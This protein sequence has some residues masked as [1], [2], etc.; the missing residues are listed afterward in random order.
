MKNLTKN[1]I[2]IYVAIMMVAVACKKEEL[3]PTPP[4][5]TKSTAKDIAKFSFAAFSPVVDATIDATA[6]T[7]K[8]TLPIGTDV[9]KLIPTITISDKASVSPA[10]GA[11]QDFIK[12]VTYTV[13]AEDGTTQAYIVTIV[14]TPKT[15]EKNILT[16]SFNGVVPAVKAIIDTTAKTIT[17][18]LSMGTDINK[19]IPTITISN[20][21]SISPIS[22]LAQN[23]TNLINYTVTA[24]DGSTKIY[25]M[26]VT[27]DAYYYS[28][29]RMTVGEDKGFIS[30]ND[31]CLL[32]YR[33][34]QVFLLKDGAK[35]ANNIDLV[36]NNYCAITLNTPVVLKNNGQLGG[37]GRINEIV[38]PQK[39][40]IYRSGD[41]DWIT[42]NEVQAGGIAY[43]QIASTD[44]DNLAFAADIDARFSTGRKLDQKN[45]V[46]II[47]TNLVDS[48]TANCTPTTL[49]DKVLYRFISQ[50]GKKGI[51]RVTSFGKKANGGYYVTIDIKI[52]K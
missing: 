45:D 15:S 18:L 30:E 11:A 8:A 21:A 44:W 20:K 7:I 49:F 14:V 24:E 50:E 33:T 52:Q 25:T 51:L 36:L 16:V 19:L 3:M 22:G 9:T 47:G 32:N 23:F 39:W 29:I 5:V 6:K 43:G 2:A 48:S 1:L 41:I 27:T 37:F 35:N 34:G 4:V 13:T 40:S 12:S 10:T 38:T 31:S 26:K 46:N 28:N 17:A 42:K